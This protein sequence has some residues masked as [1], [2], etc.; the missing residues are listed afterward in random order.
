MLKR[1]ISLSF[2]LLSYTLLFAQTESS[3]FS[4]ALE[5]AESGNVNSMFDVATMYSKGI[6][7]AKDVEKAIYWYKKAYKKDGDNA[8]L[9]ADNLCSLFLEEYGLTKADYLIQDFFYSDK[10]EMNYRLGE[11][12]RSTLEPQMIFTSDNQER[13]QKAIEYY[14]LAYDKGNKKAVKY[15]PSLFLKLNKKDYVRA[16]HYYDKGIVG[17]APSGNDFKDAQTCPIAEYWSVE[18]E[19]APLEYQA[20]E[21][22][23]QRTPEGQLVRAAPA[24]KYVYAPTYRMHIT[25]GVI[26]N[27]NKDKEVK[28]PWN[29]P[30]HRFTWGISVGYAQK[31]F[32]ETQ[33]G[34]TKT[35]G[36]WK[37]NPMSGVQVGV[38]VNPQFDHGFGFDTGLFYEYY[39]DAASDHAVPA[40]YNKEGSCKATF[41]EHGVYVPLHAEYSLHLGKSF[42]FFAFGGLGVNCVLNSTE[43]LRAKG[44]SSS[45]EKIN[46]SDAYGAEGYKKFAA[47]FEYGGGF[48]VEGLQIRVTKGTGL[49]NISNNG[50]DVKVDRLNVAVSVQL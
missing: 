46:E 20:D 10:A 50:G 34:E 11:L 48:S 12:Y 29:S 17:W 13:L 42:R 24:K 5:K 25:H 3:S 45:W 23:A 37:S 41:Q 39:Y 1:I 2:A 32:K 18:K 8:E 33:G 30:A 19:L 7:T 38:R 40:R 16:K 43:M 9:C 6:G 21:I 31:A 49:N 22:K 44:E 26:S 28:L 35:H 4:T 27:T 15:L 14:E 47:T 36:W